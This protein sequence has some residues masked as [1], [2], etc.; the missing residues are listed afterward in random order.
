MLD[1]RVPGYRSL[2]ELRAGTV[3]AEHEASGHRV[4][5]RYHQPGPEAVLTTRRA[6]ARALAGID[7]P[8]IAPLYEHIEV[9]LPGHAEAAV[10]AVTV[11]QFVA[12]AS[13]RSLLSRSR[14][15]RS[16]SS[17]TD[18]LPPESA[19]SLLRAGLLALH[20]AHEHGVTHRGYK[21]ENLL[22][23]ADG[24]ARL[25]DFGLGVADAGLADVGLADVGLADRSDLP[26]NSESS[27]PPWIRS[28]PWIGPE[29]RHGPV[30]ESLALSWILDDMRAAFAVFVTCLGGR[31]DRLPRKLRAVA[32]AG[33]AG[34]GATLLEAVEQAGRAG[35]GPQWRS[36]GEQELARR[37]TR[38]RR[39]GEVTA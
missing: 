31:V 22:V 3:L 26:E 14:S 8:H 9:A 24:S 5:L 20:C 18:E 35:W 10:G 29:G 2:R 19:L 6:E 38:A 15:G 7:S 30:A 25:A 21:P 33:E 12:G 39:R 11:R 4:L 13:V 16:E 34:D 36:R 37:V 17:R 28:A 27:P 23:G 1:W 32:A